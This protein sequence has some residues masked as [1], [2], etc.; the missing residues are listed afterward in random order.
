VVGLGRSAVG[1]GLLGLVGHFSV[2]VG[3]VVSV[4][5]WSP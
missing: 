4:R 3:T 5:P 1:E 2:S